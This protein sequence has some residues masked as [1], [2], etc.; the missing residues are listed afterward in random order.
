[1]EKFVIGA[2]LFMGAGLVLIAVYVLSGGYMEIVLIAGLSLV[3]AMLGV[4]LINQRRE[5]DARKRA[6]KRR[7]LNRG[8]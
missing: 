4:I 1:M 5:L 8:M 6:E 2:F 3:I 7:E